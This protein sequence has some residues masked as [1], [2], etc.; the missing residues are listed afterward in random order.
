MERPCALVA[1]QRVQWCALPPPPLEACPLDDAW[2]MDE[3]AMDEPAMD[4][5]LAD[6]RL[7]LLKPELLP[8]LAANCGVGRTWAN[9]DLTTW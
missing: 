8:E 6:S 1:G 2:P 7:A 5:P 3:P 4:D 9:P